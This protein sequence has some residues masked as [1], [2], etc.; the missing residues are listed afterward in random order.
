MNLLEKIKATLS[1]VDARKA[2]DDYSIAVKAFVDDMQR[3]KAIICMENFSVNM[4][5]QM[6]KKKHAH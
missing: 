3:E 2:S 1:T 5:L 6:K 4:K